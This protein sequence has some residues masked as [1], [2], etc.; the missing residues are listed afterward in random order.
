M[1]EVKP[2]TIFNDYKGAMPL[3][4]DLLAA[5]EEDDT[6]LEEIVYQFNAWIIEE[7]IKLWGQ[8]VSAEQHSAACLC[9]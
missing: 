2:Q 6:R 3:S 9:S 8:A 1:D 5:F 4:G 7:C